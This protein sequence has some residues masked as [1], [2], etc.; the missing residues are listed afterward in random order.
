MLGGTDRAFLS[1]ALDSATELKLLVHFFSLWTFGK[2]C[3]MGGEQWRLAIR[4][5]MISWCYLLGWSVTRGGFR[6][7][8]EM[9]TN[10]LSSVKNRTRGRMLPSWKAAW[11]LSFQKHSGRIWSG[12]E[13]WHQ[14]GKQQGSILSGKAV[15]YCRKNRLHGKAWWLGKRFKVKVSIM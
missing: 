2:F 5:W 11:N 12:H 15:F 3:G 6:R 13:S 8:L 1:N 4:S 10:S 9:T 7:A 14:W